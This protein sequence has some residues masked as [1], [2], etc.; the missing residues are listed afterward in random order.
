MAVSIKI[1]ITQNSQSVNDNTSNVT[2]KL[3]AS[4]TG[5][6]NNRVVNA[7][8][9][10]QA[11]GS[12]TIN[13]DPYTFAK[14]FNDNQTTTGSKEIF[15]KTLDI[16]HNSDGTKT[17]T[18]SA[19]Y[20]TGVSSGMVRDTE[21]KTLTTIP[22]ASELTIPAPTLN[23]KQTL[24]VKRKSD[25]FTHTVKVSCGSTAS[26]ITVCTKS[27]DTSL[28]FTPPIEW[29]EYN[30]TGT[31]VRIVYSIATYNGNTLVATAKQYT[32]TGTI[33]S[34]VKPSCSITVTDPMGWAD[35]DK[36]GAYIKG[37]SKIKVVVT[38]TTSYGSA[39]ASYKTTVNGSTYTG[40]SF[41][42]NILNTSGTL[43]ITATVTDKRGRTGTA[44]VDVDV[45]DYELP[46]ITSL[47]VRRCDADGTLNDQ[48][49]SAQIEFDADISDPSLDRHYNSVAYTLEYKKSADT[50]YTLVDLVDYDDVFDI[51]G[52]IYV[53]PAESGSSY[54]IRLT[55][56][57][58]FGSYTKTTRVSTTYTIMHWKTSG[59]GMAIG[60]VSEL[61]D[62]F[63]VNMQTRLLGGLLYVE[64]EPETDLN[65]IRTPGFYVGENV[66]S[67]N[68]SNCPITAGTFIF[69]VLS[70]GINGQVLQRLTRCDKLKP[71]VFQRWW[72]GDE[73]G[74][75]H[76]AGSDEVLLYENTSGTDD[77]VQ[78]RLNNDP[79]NDYVNASHFRYL[80][81]YFTDNNGRGSGY[82]KVWNPD[83]RTIDL[84]LTEASSTIYSRQTAYT[85][86]GYQLVPDLTTASYYRITS[87]GVVNTS[88]G[89]N[90][91]KIIRV[92]GRP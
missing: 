34:S 92:V 3:T 4:W 5:G 18:C 13:G 30:T 7:Q 17:L 39:I 41:T 70:G 8:G 81:I 29:A 11:N 43:T 26:T 42:T 27:S 76:G 63:D 9:V 1:A 82:V 46:R 22:R 32:V 47:A 45:L 21:D 28:E 58:D 73:W 51:T 12:V 91:I 85:I 49:E 83:D 50:D 20:E 54:D 72:Y 2:V 52:A 71:L 64:L 79:N 90:Y 59:R 67:Y 53:F 24:T 66:S 57:D 61:E 37:Q 87:A 38:P 15:S 88:I 77:T 74:V 86:E 14:T 56:T 78:L 55:A 68:Y 16:P 89:T 75:W 25:K 60:K 62:V 19:W 10:P 65:E 23:T 36:Y 40:A 80:E 6:S 84:H 33:P 48:G 31:T 69:E 35:T 44:S